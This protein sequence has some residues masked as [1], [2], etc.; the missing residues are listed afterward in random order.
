VS[1]SVTGNRDLPGAAASA[2]GPRADSSAASAPFNPRR[3]LLWLAVGATVGLALA[4][5][6]LLTATDTGFKAVPVGAVALVNGRQIL[7]RDL[8]AQAETEYGRPIKDIT[9][10]EKKSVLESMIREELLVQRGLEIEVPKTD[11]D[12]RQ[13]IVNAVNLV[14]AAE[15]EATQPSE[16]EL[17]AYF[18]A[19]LEN[20]VVFGT[21]Q[22]RDLVLPV[23]A[24]AD[25]AALTDAEA[26]A[27]QAAGA[28]GSDPSDAAIAAV[29]ARFGLRDNGPFTQAGKDGIPT[30]REVTEPV[31]ARTLGGVLYP[32]V[33]A[34]GH[35][36]VSAPVRTPD[37]FHLLVV[38]A[39]QPKTYFS[40]DQAR[41]R[42]EHEIKADAQAKAEEEQLHDLRTKAEILIAP[43][44]TP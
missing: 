22:L 18:A 6:S 16:A 17:Q 39:H 11:P 41:S 2:A 33:T 14:T 28:L 30:A 27:R 24:A 8:D 1:T 20:Y 13:A 37:G 40:F 25:A 29:A 5:Y 44:F 7:Q 4:G 31:A 35:R 3:S 43:G 36:G 21:Y 34:L 10:A 38:R 23:A 42:V 19:H 9:L 32:A 26:K 12:V 15:V